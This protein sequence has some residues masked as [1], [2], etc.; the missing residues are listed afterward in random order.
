MDNSLQKI[1]KRENL[2]YI[3]KSVLHLVAKYK[4]IIGN[5]NF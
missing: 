1:E 3:L 2:C 4:F 5:L